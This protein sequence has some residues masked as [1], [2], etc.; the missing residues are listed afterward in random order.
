MSTE[1]ASDDAA[2]YA[3][4]VNVADP[5]LMAPD[6]MEQTLLELLAGNGQKAPENRG[7]LIRC[8]LESLALEYAVRLESMSELTGRQLEALYMV[9][10][11]IANQLLCRLTADA[12]GIVVHAGAEQCTA[13]GNALCQA[14]ALGD[15]GDRHEIRQ[16]MRNSFQSDTY[17][18]RDETAWQDKRI[19]YR[20]L[21]AL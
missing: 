18:P 13:M 4:L 5:S 19:R 10:G 12:C 14:L 3:G 15:L 17:E 9:G 21:T 16:V 7:Q 8:V 20:K 6:D 11:G 2:A 1:A